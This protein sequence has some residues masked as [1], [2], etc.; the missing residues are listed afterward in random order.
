MVLLP[1]LGF[2]IS[3]LLASLVFPTL[4]LVWGWEH[5]KPYRVGLLTWTN[6]MHRLGELIA[7]VL[8]LASMYSVAAV[9]FSYL[10]KESRS[11]KRDALFWFM[12]CIPMFL[13]LGC[14]YPLTSAYHEF[15][16]LE[17]PREKLWVV[18]TCVWTSVACLLVMEVYNFI[19]REQRHN[20]RANPAPDSPIPQT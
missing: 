1:R 7:I 18:M 3:P 15:Q 9:I 2:A 4:L 11:D 17:I 6:D 14:S 8:P 19:T 20:R 13:L 12:Y 10:D 16:G 5:T